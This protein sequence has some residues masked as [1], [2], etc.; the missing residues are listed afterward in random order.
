MGLVSYCVSRGIVYNN[1]FIRFYSD[2]K[3]NEESDIHKKQKGIDEK[4]IINFYNDGDMDS[5]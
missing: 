1:Y 3:K 4:A 5:C 2:M